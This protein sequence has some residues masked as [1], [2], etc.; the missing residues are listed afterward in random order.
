MTIIEQPAE[1]ID[2]DRFGRPL[3]VPPTG[4]KPVPYTRCTTYVS[5][6]EDTFN[7][8]Q[9]QQR[10][11]AIGLST[12]ADLLLAVSGA[13]DDRTALNKICDDAREA[14]AAS[15]AAT[16]GTALHQLTERMDRGLDLPPVPEAYQ[17]DL[18]AYEKA[19][20]DL[21]A[22]HIE[23]FTVVDN[24]RIGGTPDRVVEIGGKRYIADLKTGSIRYGMGK[25]AMQLAV[26][27]HAKGYDI[28]SRKRFD[29][30]DIDRDTGIVIHLP[31]GKGE[32]ELVAVDIKAGWTAVGLA[33]DVRNWRARRNLSW[34]WTAS[35][36]SLEATLVAS[37]IDEAKTVDDLTYI[38]AEHQDAWTDDLTAR[39]AARKTEIANEGATA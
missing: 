1:Q 39:A 32:C 25:I 13:Q 28:A 14:A 9:W 21:T 18:A 3:V 8:S 11:V 23:Q 20:A 24:L 7:L 10:M 6:L 12:R 30:G 33:T 31:A 38:W 2:R 4:G 5:C 16:T 34:S 37:L 17:A 15:A 36:E 26:Y 27:A 22:I 29:L 19:T 35:A